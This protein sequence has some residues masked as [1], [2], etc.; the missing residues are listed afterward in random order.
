M[1][2]KVLTLLG[3]A[4]KAGKLQYGVQKTAECLKKDTARLIVCACDLSEKTKK[5]ILFFASREK[6][7]VVI[8]EDV[9][10]EKLSAAI[11]RK[12][13]TVSVNDQGFA[14]AI[15]K[16]SGGYANDQQI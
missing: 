8:L 15:S 16:I 4:A 10:I 7:N 3:F 11:G 12:C 1:N 5:E 13:G 9:T 14:D 2:N 6:I